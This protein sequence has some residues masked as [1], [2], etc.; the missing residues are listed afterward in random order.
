[1]NVDVNNSKAPKSSKKK[2]LN[3]ERVDE[4]ANEDQENQSAHEHTDMDITEN[5][6]EP[7]GTDEGTSQLVLTEEEKELLKNLDLEYLKLQ[8]GGNQSMRKINICSV[9]EMAVSPS[10]LLECQGTCQQS[11]HFDCV[12]LLALP[13]EPFKCDECKN[14]LHVCFLCKEPQLSDENQEQT[15]STLRKCVSNSCGKYFH[16]Q[17]AKSNPL[18]RPVSNVQN[19]YSF[20]CSHH[21]CRT[22]W[23]KNKSE[24]NEGKSVNSLQAFKGRFVRCIRCPTAYHTSDFCVAAGSMMLTNNNIICPDHFRP[25]RN[26]TQHNRVNVSWCFVC[27]DKGNLIGCNQCPASYH[28]NCLE[29]P[30]HLVAQPDENK[31]DSQPHSPSSTT[32][33]HNTSNSANS[34]RIKSVNS[35]NWTCEDCLDGKRPLYGQI[36]WAKVGG[37][38]WWPA[39]VCLPRLLPEN[40]LKRAHQVGEFAVRFFGSNDYFWLTIRRCYGFVD[41]D[42]IMGSV[43]NRKS[44]DV[45]YKKGIEEAKVAFKEIEI[46]K[47]ERLTKTTGREAMKNAKGNFHFIKTNKPYGNATIYKVPLADLPRCDCDP[48]SANPC[49]TD[50]C[51]NRVLKYECHPSICPAGQ[52]CQNQRFVK[53]QYPKQ[54]PIF[55]GERGWGLRN[56][57]DI[58]KG[59]FVN[60]YVGELIDNQEL[61]RRLDHAHQNS[62]HNFYFLT[63]DKDR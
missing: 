18:F 23:A 55:T 53:K 21:T 13:T 35:A 46:L 25:L 11:F 49:G 28:L 33:S 48:K 45:M 39:Q 44:L 31:I 24:C 30:P 36:V 10:T 34:N 38:R 7:N 2:K 59:D 20:L 61:K 37:Y 27:C 12:G 57:V 4:Q 9:C 22:C 63:I 26:Q 41:G 15:V 32:S 47:A 54:E 17:C 3:E 60:E 52:R 58:K 6:K 1:M 43:N 19:K 8:P 14:G 56:L 40:I 29:N 51:M 5:E 50:D 42:D 16:E 62:V